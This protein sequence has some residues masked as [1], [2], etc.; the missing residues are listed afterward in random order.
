MLL[1][2]LTLAACDAHI[3]TICGNSI[4]TGEYV[5]IIV[6]GEAK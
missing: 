1:F 6:T 5:C 3:K 2:V 4:S